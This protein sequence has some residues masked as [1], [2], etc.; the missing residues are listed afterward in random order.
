MFCRWHAGIKPQLLDTQYRM[1]PS[2][3]AFPSRI[4]YGGQ[5]RT[6]VK[7]EDRLV[8]QPSGDQFFEDC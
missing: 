1:H 2:I 3:A 8:P 6:G 5:L 4:F 7:A